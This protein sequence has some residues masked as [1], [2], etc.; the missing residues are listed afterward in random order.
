MSDDYVFDNA[1]SRALSRF[2]E[3]SRLYD[4]NT[5][6]H[7][8]EVGIDEGWSCLEVGVGGGSIARW[9]CKRVGATGRVVATDIDPT[10]LQAL[11]FPTLEVHRHDIR[12]E[13]LPA[14]EFDLVHVRMV[15]MHLSERDAALERL[16]TALKPGGWIVIEEFDDL[17]LLPEPAS[18]PGEISLKVRRALQHALA[19]RGVDLRYGRLLLS[20]LHTL[21]LL[22]TGSEA[23]ASIWRAG[24]PGIRLLKLTCEELRESIIDSGL[25]SPSEF[26]DD[27]KAIDRCD[28]SLPS[29]MLWTAWGQLL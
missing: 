27:M 9:L 7:I 21:G 29:P 25:M 18:Y 20:R 28:F 4:A 16:V 13:P 24:S 5:I 22:N 6:R 1:G 15:L 14:H 23:S 17:T 19:A 12:V 10:F 3:L 2:L 11:S 8:E 26:D